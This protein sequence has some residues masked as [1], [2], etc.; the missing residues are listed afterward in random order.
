MAFY[1]PSSAERE[2]RRRRF[3]EPLRRPAAAANSIYRTRPLNR[4]EV[5]RSEKGMSE[6]DTRHLTVSAVPRELCDRMRE[7]AE[8]N[9]SS[10]SAEVRR[11]RSQHAS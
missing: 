2:F 5:C 1:C 6:T 11:A 3:E 9:L 8:A 7:I 10:L 4:F